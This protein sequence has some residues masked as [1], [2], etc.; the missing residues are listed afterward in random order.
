M[1]QV[2]VVHQLHCLHMVWR[3]HH[4][5][6]FPDEEAAREKRPGFYEAHYEHCVDMIRQRIMCTAD[7]G[8]ITFRWIEGKKGPEPDFNTEHQCRNIEATMDRTREMEA[9]VPVDYIQWRKPD[10]AVMLSEPP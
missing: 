4:L 10:D 6:Y 5:S 8:L 1:A 9:S 3:D 2:A 7:T